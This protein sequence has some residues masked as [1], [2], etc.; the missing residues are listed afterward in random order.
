VLRVV[1][2][3]DLM[4]AGAATRSGFRAWPLEGAQAL[5]RIERLWT[6]GVCPRMGELFWLSSTPAGDARGD[7]L[8]RG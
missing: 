3:Q 4:R 5:A 8:L 6:P 1:L 7:A 2:E